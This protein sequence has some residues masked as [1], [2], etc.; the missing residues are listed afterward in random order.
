MGGRA[1]GV[2]RVCRRAR[3]GSMESLVEWLVEW[4]VESLVESLV[5]WA[6]ASRVV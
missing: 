6:D 4:L 1:A 5:E 3:G 2:W